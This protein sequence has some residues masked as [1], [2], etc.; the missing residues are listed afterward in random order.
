MRLSL[1]QGL[2]A[3]L[4]GGLLAAFWTFTL[5]HARHE[6]R[7]HLRGPLDDALAG[8]RQLIVAAWHQDVVPFFHYLITYTSIERRR[9]FVMLASRSFDGELTERI[10]K[11]W[12]IRFVRGSAGKEGAHAALKGL[13]RALH[14]GE[15][16]IVIADGPAPPPFRMQPGPVYLARATGVPLYLARAWGRPQLL[17]PRAWFRPALPLPRSDIALFSDGPV[18]VGGGIEESRRRAELG[19]NR[20]CEEAD[21]HLYL[22]PRVTGGVPLS[23][24]RAPV[25]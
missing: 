13:V 16:A 19:L 15:S 2:A 4:F 17:V 18:D 14:A 21:A 5:R 22:R 7:W 25:I 12:G 10:L 8:G 23:R 9:A 1:R 24:R 20:L 6:C 11:T 3:S